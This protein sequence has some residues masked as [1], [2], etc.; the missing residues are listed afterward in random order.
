MWPRLLNL[1]V[2]SGGDARLSICFFAL[3]REVVGYVTLNF[4]GASLS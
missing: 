3:L 1:P 4:G 2:V